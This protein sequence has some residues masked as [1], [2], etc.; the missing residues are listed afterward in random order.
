[1]NQMPFPYS[2]IPTF[3]LS[4]AAPASDLWTRIGS[5]Y[6]ESMQ[7]SAQELWAS[8]ARIIQ[9]HTTRA[10]IEAS[11]SCMQALAENAA[12]VQQRA[13]AQMIKDHQK[14]TDIV[15]AQV[16]ATFAKALQPASS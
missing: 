6:K 14:A 5:V 3:D 11:Q 8:S 1:M 16:G 15:T 7:Q 4:A 2:L 9:E 12:A 13:F 10:W